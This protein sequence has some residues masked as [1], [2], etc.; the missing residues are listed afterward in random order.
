MRLLTKLVNQK[1]LK[2][3]PFK[4]V[5]PLFA[6]ISIFIVMLLTAHL[7]YIIEIEVQPS[8]I[9]EHSRS[10]WLSMQFGFLDLKDFSIIWL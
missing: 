2:D 9:D 3:E 6:F 7:G 4:T 10:L 5:W 1:E 8:D